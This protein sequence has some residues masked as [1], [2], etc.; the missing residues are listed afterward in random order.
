M[1]R[2]IDQAGIRLRGMGLL[3]SLL[4]V[5]MAGL[6][7]CDSSTPEVG[8]NKSGGTGTTGPKLRGN[9]LVDGSSTVRPIGEAVAK[10][11]AD[12][13]PDVKIEVGGRG[14]GNGFKR[15]ASKEID[16][17]QASRPVSP[18]EVKQLK[19]AGV[20]FLEIP[21]AYDG[22]TIVVHPENDWVKQLTVDQLKQIYGEGATAANWS[23]LDPTWPAEPLKLFAPGTGSGTYDYFC[24]V[25]G[26]KL[27]EGI[28]LNEDDNALVTGVAGNRYSIGFFGVAYFEENREKLRA[29]PIVNPETGEPCLPERDAIENNRYAP[30]SRPL[31]IYVNGQSLDRLE[32]KM[33]LKFYLDSVSE[34]APNVGYVRLPANIWQKVEEIAADPQSHM[35]TKFV[36][37]AGEKVHGSFSDIFLSAPAAA[38]APNAD[39]AGQP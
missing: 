16:F 19:E 14:T 38:A 6:A 13:Q 9:I 11:F 33:F 17:S 25:L 32:V 31:F 2:Q 34:L 39:A 10:R 37:E 24:E 7:G 23:D 22:L 35:G 27:R 15:F 28:S 30:F 4:C 21:V 20:P 36:T 5:L 26:S 8:G 3:G 18:S 12:T 29:V 1:A